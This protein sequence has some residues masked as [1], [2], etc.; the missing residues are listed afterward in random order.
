M[1]DTTDTIAAS[2]KE[3]DNILGLFREDTKTQ[4]NKLIEKIKEKIKNYEDVEK[5]NMLSKLEEIYLKF[6]NTQDRFSL[7]NSDIIS[8]MNKEYKDKFEE[9]IKT[10]EKK[11][12]INVEAMI[13]YE[14]DNY[15]QP[16]IKTS[17]TDPGINP[18]PSG[19]KDPDGPKS[20]SSGSEDPLLSLK[21]L[22]I[23]EE[24]LKA[25]Y[26]QLF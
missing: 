12:L 9:K 16:E 22:E 10:L 5:K 24:Y 11:P 15:F 20:N 7:I 13:L 2:I 8:M 6:K 17:S 26:A 21:Q 14:I 19:S 1:T 25:V 18:N 3:F 23:L 4:N